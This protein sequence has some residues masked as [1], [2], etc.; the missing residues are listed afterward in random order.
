MK[1]R[2]LVTIS[3]QSRLR[4]S[5][6][7]ARREKECEVSLSEHERKLLAQMEEALSADDPRLVSTLTGNRLYP[8]RNRVI[9]GVTLVLVGLA[10]LFGGLIAKTTPIGILGFVISLVG[11]TLAISAVSDLKGLHLPRKRGG[12]NLNSRLED[13]WERRNF[14]N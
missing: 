6:V 11:V 13:R 14:D 1:H 10:T 2:G 9:L 3:M 4:C 5:I 8:G 12:T 7:S